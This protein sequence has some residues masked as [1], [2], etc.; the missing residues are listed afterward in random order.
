VDAA[1]EGHRRKALQALC[2]DPA[3]QLWS[4]AAPLLDEMVEATK[5][6]LPQFH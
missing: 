3:I 4:V 5:A 2:M 6:Y 1:T